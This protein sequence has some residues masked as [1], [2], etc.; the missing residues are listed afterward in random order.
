MSAMLTWRPFQLMTV[1]VG[2][3]DLAKMATVGQALEAQKGLW[4]KTSNG[5]LVDYKNAEY[6]EGGVR[7][8]GDRFNVK[9]EWLVF[10][11]PEAGQELEAIVTRITDDLLILIP[12][13]ISHLTKTKTE[14]QVPWDP[15]ELPAFVGQSFKAEWSTLIGLDC[16]DPALIGPYFHSVAMPAL[17]CHKEPIVLHSDNEGHYHQR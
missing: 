8:V 16:Q 13:E 15:T 10:T 6:H 1:K 4:E 3:R 5:V 12:K 9:A 17:L 2:P 7:Y 14:V 11:K